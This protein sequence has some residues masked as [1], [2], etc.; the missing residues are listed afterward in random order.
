MLGN[1][2]GDVYVGLHLGELRSAANAA[3]RGA[4]QRSAAR[5]L[6]R[7][8]ASGFSGLVEANA[9]QCALSLLTRYKQH[10]HRTFQRV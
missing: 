7:D 1:E 3:R 2:G 9:I 8:R 10:G 5:T 6:N 4:A